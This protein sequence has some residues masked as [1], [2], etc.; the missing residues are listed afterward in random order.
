MKFNGGFTVPADRE[1][2]FA[3]LNDPVFFS[4][5]LD[6]VSDLVEIDPTH[7][8]ARLATRIAYIKFNF[9]IAIEIADIVAP[10][11]VVARAEGTP[12]GIVG[13]L[14]ALATADLAETEG[15]T[16]VTYEIDVSL[17]GKLGAIGQPVLR[18]KAREM[19]RSFVE[20]LHA[21][22]AVPESIGPES[23]GPEDAAQENAP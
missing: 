23:I 11:R 7:Y 16:E 9:A 12:L 1:T 18:S 19:E 20:K 14:T 10:S 15:Q 21:A 8:T 22:F 6:G 5:C 2:V 13:R 3:R 17:A 4:S